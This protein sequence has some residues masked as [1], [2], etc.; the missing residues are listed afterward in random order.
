MMLFLQPKALV[1]LLLKRPFTAYYAHSHMHVQVG[2]IRFLYD[3]IVE[4]LAQY[5]STPGFGCIL[6]HSMGLG[7]TMQVRDMCGH[8]TCG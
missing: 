4:S 2:G 1:Y 8:V 7:K 6:A 5:D 3:N